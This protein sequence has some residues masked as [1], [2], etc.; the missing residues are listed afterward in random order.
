MLFRSMT[1]KARTIMVTKAMLMILSAARISKDIH[2]HLCF[3]SEI[4]NNTGE[5]G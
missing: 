2:E 1:L 3:E 4:Q 5:L